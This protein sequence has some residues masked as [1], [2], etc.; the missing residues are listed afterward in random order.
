M[1]SETTEN[2]S[3]PI[4]LVISVSILVAVGGGWLLYDHFAASGAPAGQARAPEATAPLEEL[5]DEVPA[6][7]AD[8]DV[9][10][11]KARL[12]AGAGVLTDPEGQS[13]LHLYGL[14]LAADP[15]HEAARAELDGILDR[16]SERAA[17]YL[18]SG[19]YYDAH[20][21]AER[22]EAVRPAHGLVDRVRQYL[23]E[24]ERTKLTEAMSQAE[25]GEFEAAMTLVSEAENLPGG[26]L[27]DYAAVRGSIEEMR[28]AQEEAEQA[29]RERL[30]TERRE[31]QQQLGAWMDRVRGAIEQGKLVSPAG[32]N[33]REYFEARTGSGEASAAIREELMTAMVDRARMLLNDDDLPAAESMLASAV[34][35][36]GETEATARVAGA[37]EA[38]YVERESSTVRAISD[39]VVVERV[40]A[41]YPPRLVARGV[42]GWVELAFTVTAS[43]KTAEIE[44]LNAEPEEAF[45]VSAIEAVEQ[46]RF[47]PRT[48][49]GTPI[50]QRTM[51]RL[52]YRLED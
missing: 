31:E 50:S 49:R 14:V 21:L 12:A 26:E 9:S 6:A 19:A 25:S 40:P 43:G 39:F 11:R 10:L 51:A 18:E 46:W 45:N 36:G 32:D 23:D 47:E 3:I 7:D 15:D 30:E 27:G 35:F 28:A 38:H 34:D 37:I 8:I 13:A 42:T 17:E 22:V 20:R 33:A 2:S 1:M 52:V 16:L 29:E 48:F 24:L 44:V 41:E 4:L 5:P